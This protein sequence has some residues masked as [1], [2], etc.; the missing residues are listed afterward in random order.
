[1]ILGVLPYISEDIAWAALG[2]LNEVRDELA[3]PATP[4]PPSV[5]FAMCVF[6][7]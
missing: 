3:A 4:I 5:L 1:M 2:A 7:P 6:S